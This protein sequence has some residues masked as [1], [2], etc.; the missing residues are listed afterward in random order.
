L[1]RT[2]SVSI[3]KLDETKPAGFQSIFEHQLSGNFAN[4]SVVG[5]TSAYR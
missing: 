2:E 1:Q 5:R 4:F 3:D